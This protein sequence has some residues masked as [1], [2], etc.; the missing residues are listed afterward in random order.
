[1]SKLFYRLDTV[2]KGFII[3][4]NYLIIKT[5]FFINNDPANGTY[6]VLKISNLH[7]LINLYLFLFSFRNYD[8]FFNSSMHK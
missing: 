7:A 2:Q 1:M 5:I 3:S 4:D 8:F 6:N